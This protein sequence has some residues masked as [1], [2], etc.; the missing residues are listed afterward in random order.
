MDSLLPW[1]VWIIAAAFGFSQGLAVVVV[2][3]INQFSRPTL[4][5]HSNE[6]YQWGPERAR[7]EAAITIPP[8]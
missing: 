5:V 6:A 3:A 8:M 4:S 7:D 1:T 2:R